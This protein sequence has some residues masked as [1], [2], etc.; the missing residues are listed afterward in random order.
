[1]LTDAQSCAGLRP[2]TSADTG[3]RAETWSSTGTC[4][5][6]R[7]GHNAGTRSSTGSSRGNWTPRP[8]RRAASLSFF[9]AQ[10]LKYTPRTRPPRAAPPPDRAARRGRGGRAPRTADGPG[11]VRSSPPLSLSFLSFS[12]SFLFL[13]FF[14]F[15]LFSS[16]SLF[17]FFSFLP[18][19]LTLPAVCICMIWSP[20]MATKS[21]KCTAQGRRKRRPCR[22]G[23]AGSPNRVT[24]VEIII[25]CA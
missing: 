23:T 1:M 5:S 3:S 6:T 17:S 2:S 8:N 25:H 12:L 11:L 16:F 9:M 24:N 14:L 18:L 13:S 10:T 22:S 4:R 19:S 15:S 21:Y 20:I 7:T